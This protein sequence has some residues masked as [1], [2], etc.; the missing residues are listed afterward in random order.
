MT[1]YS[2]IFHLKLYNAFS[3][4]H[5]LTFYFTM[6]KT[7]L[8]TSCKLFVE[9]ISHC[10]KLISLFRN[11]KKLMARNSSC[12]FW[13]SFWMRNDFTGIMDNL[14]K[15]SFYN[16]SIFIATQQRIWWAHN[17][18]AISVYKIQINISVIYFSIHIWKMC[19][20]YTVRAAI[21]R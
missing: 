14:Y 20:I 16:K 5:F 13:I 9:T 6:H 3:R 4:Y 17:K 2:I 7:F 10:W 19:Y 15:N 11:S 1:T 12:N 21:Y 8:R 18:V